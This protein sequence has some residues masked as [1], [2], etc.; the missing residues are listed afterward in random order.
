MTNW[1]IESLE[2]MMTL[3]GQF[4]YIIVINSIHNDMNVLCL[5]FILYSSAENEVDV[6]SYI[7]YPASPTNCSIVYFSVTN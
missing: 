2:I 5:V 3:I 1:K 4:Y 7:M 6:I